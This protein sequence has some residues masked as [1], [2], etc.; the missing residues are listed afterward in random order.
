M[1]EGRN[2][3]KILTGN[4]AGK[5]SLGR[6]RW[7]VCSAQNRDYW[8]SFSEPPGFISHGV[9][10]FNLLVYEGWGLNHVS[11]SMAKLRVH[12]ETWKYINGCEWC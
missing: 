3:F 4:P 7:R 9:N 11:Y 6:A 2:A 10:W 12:E 1:E 8:R 5:R